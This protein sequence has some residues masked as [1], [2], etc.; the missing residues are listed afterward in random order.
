MDDTEPAFRLVFDHVWRTP[1]PGTLSIADYRSGKYLA[2]DPRTSDVFILNEEGEILN[3]WNKIGESDTEIGHRLSGLCFF[4]DSSVIL[5]GTKAHYVYHLDGSYIRKYPHVDHPYGNLL[6]TQTQLT[7]QDGQVKI[8]AYILPNT[9][10]PSSVAEFYQQA[11]LLTVTDPITGNRIYTLPYP[12]NSIYRKTNNGYYPS[13]N[14][15]FN[16]HASSD[17]IFA[18]FQWDENLY[19][20]KWKGDELQLEQVIPMKPRYFKRMDPIPYGQAAGDA[21]D[22]LRHWFYNSA[23]RKVMVL[24]DET[25]LTLY[26][27]GLPEKE[28]LTADWET[29]EARLY[30]LDKRMLQVFRQGEKVGGDILLPDSIV[31][32]ELAKGFDFLMGTPSH[33]HLEEEPPTQL[34]FIYRLEP[35]QN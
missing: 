32:I 19:H 16:A 35:I 9:D 24:E 7:R 5:T 21:R 12:E 23:Y 29:Y 2:R 25:V 8:V 4:N 30:Q 28:A 31:D 27:S 1:Y 26:R 13:K 6:N 3:Q 33:F 17:Q 34:F 14:I 22:A 18:T 10:Y 15:I 11:K 20:Y